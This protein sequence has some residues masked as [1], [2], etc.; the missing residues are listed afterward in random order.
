MLSVR[1]IIQLVIA[2]FELGMGFIGKGIIEDRLGI[3]IEISFILM[4]IAH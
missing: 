1:I 3:L 2:Q 4:T